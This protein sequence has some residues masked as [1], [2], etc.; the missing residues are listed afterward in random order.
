MNTE[1]GEKL[2]KA[3]NSTD[4][5]VWKDKNGNDIKLMTASAK[6]IENW[7]NHC[8]NMLYNSNVH[9]PGKYIIRK[10]IYNIWDSCNTEL[11]V[12]YLL[13]E[14]NTNIKTKKD[15][16]DYINDQK[17]LYDHDILS[18]SISILFEGLDPIYEKIT[19]NKLLDACFDKLDVINRKMINDKF[20]L[21]QGIWLTDDEKIDL[22]ETDEKG[23]VKNRIDVIKERLSLDPKIKIKINPN[24][25]TFAEFRS[26]VQLSPISRISVL[27]TITLKTLRDKILLLLDND[28]NYHINKWNVL[29]SNIRRVAEIRNISLPIYNEE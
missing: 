11:F 8:H 7:Y 22:T 23:N 9:N 15:I 3:I 6:D 17:S 4:S 19:V 13:N 24:G 27:P 26:I 5:F 14:C 20:I 16:L 28:L 25:L 1:F 10:N 2:Q 21:A 29:K 18:E 12:R